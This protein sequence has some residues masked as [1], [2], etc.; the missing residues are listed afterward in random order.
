MTEQEKKQ[1]DSLYQYVKKEIMGYSDEQKLPKHFVL[2]LKGLSEGKFVA[3]NKIQPLAH[4]GFDIIL[5]TFKICKPNILYALQTKEFKNETNKI[6]YICAIVE[7][8]I[9][10]VYIKVKTAQET[11]VKTEN[12]DISILT[13]DAA[14]YKTKT[15]EKN[16]TEKFSD[17]W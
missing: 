1:W 9:N 4:Y 6:N 3:N 5:Y 14:T 8:N 2:R 13:N 17:L 15:T 10:D 11:K 12:V 16:M 7:R